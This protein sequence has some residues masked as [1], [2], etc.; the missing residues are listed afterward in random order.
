MNKTVKF[1]L[2]AHMVLE[3]L[4]RAIVT[5]SQLTRAVAAEAGIRT[6]QA[7]QTTYVDRHPSTR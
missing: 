6:T 5:T 3:T 4:A 2:V 1:D 7:V